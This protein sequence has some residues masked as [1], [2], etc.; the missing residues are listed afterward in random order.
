MSEFIVIADPKSHT[1]NLLAEVLRSLGYQSVIQ[2]ADGKELLQATVEFE[3]RIV[4]TTSRLPELSGLEFTRLIRAG[5]KNV[6]RLLSIIVMTDTPTRAFMD[7]A[8]ASGVDEMLV[9]PY[10]AQ[11]LAVRLKAV[12]E[13]PRPFIDSAVYVGP[14]RRRRMVE[15]YVGPKRRFLDPTEGGAGVSPWEEL[16]NRQAVRACV[17]RL[18]ELSAGLTPGDRK[19]LRDIWAAAQETQDMADQ[20][21][22]AALGVAARS[23]GRYITAVGAKGTPEQDVLATHIDAMH[24]LGQLTGEQHEERDNLAQGL[25]R[26]V[27]KRLGLTSSNKVA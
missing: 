10:S 16:S 7:A 12:T 20:T 3:P 9:N 24:T 17:T 13:R 18:S 14:C 26:V 8:Q 27:D 15:D 5:Y 11:S 1:R 22:D 4:I 25:I 23:L 19:K 6:S 21:K 2:A